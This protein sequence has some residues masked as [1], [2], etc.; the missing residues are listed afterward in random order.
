MET[1][2]VSSLQ[3]HFGFTEFRPGQVEALQS[4]MSGQHTLVVMPTGSGKSLIYQ[5]AALNF[6]GITLVL[7]PLVALMKDQ[8]DVLER[9]E[10]SA[11]FINSSLYST[12]QSRRLKNLAAGMYRLLYIAPE[13]LRSVPFLEALRHREVSLLAVDEAHCISEWGHDFRPDYLHIARFRASLGDPLTAALTA[14]ATPRVQEDITRLLNLSNIHRIVTGFN[15]PNL[16]LEV[17]Y[18]A[19]LYAKLKALKEFPIEGNG[20][21]TIIYTGTRRDSEEVADFVR[22]QVKL[23]A[24]YYHAGLGAEERDRIQDS[25]LSGKLP[26][27][28]ATKAF[29][30]GI[31]RQDVRQV[32]HYAIPGTLEAYYQEAGRAGRD[33]LPSHAVLL[34]S[35]EDRSL[36]EW[37]IE[38]S[39]VTISD[40]RMLFELIHKHPR[41]M[42][43]VTLNDLSLQLGI[44]ETK[45]KLG[46]A[47][48]E[49]AGIL[50]HSGDEGLRMQLKARDWETN[51]VQAIVEKLKQH[52]TYRQERLKDMIHYAESSHCRRIIILKYFGDPGKAEAEDCCDNCQASRPVSPSPARSTRQSEGGRVALLLLDT[53][54]WIKT[55]VGRDKVAKI[56]RGS[57]AKEIYSANLDKSPTFGC[58][59]SFSLDRIKELLDQLLEMGYLKVIGGRYPVLRLTPRGKASVQARD[60]IPLRL[61]HWVSSQGDLPDKA[62]TPQDAEGVKKSGTSPRNPRGSEISKEP[63]PVIRQIHALKHPNGNTRR[64]AASILGR[65]RDP[66]A[67][68]PLM[69]LLEREGKPQVRQY[70][71]IALG[72]IGDATA[73]ELLERIAGDDQEKIYTCQSA[74]EALNRLP[75]PTDEVAEFLAHS[76]LRPIKGPWEDGWALGFHSRFAGSDWQRSEVGE[77]AYRLKYMGDLSTLPAIIDHTLPLFEEHPELGKV[78]GVIPVPPS[79]PREQDPVS[80]YAQALSGRFGL[81]VY[82]VLIKSRHT[83]P[84]KEMRTMAQKRANVSGAFQLIKPVKGLR[85]LVVD[86]LF[87]SGATMD[88]ITRLLKR[89]G[90]LKVFVLT[91]TRTIHTSN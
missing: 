29:G 40:L 87:D 41:R 47:E 86:D 56:L 64:L 58:L 2:L 38:S 69:E 53:V 5:L 4:L 80:C 65:L 90:A 84:Q 72:K 83:Q 15:R 23:R 61:P 49:R 59:R 48:L 75:S 18:C 71:V 22:E 37:F 89:A 10:I 39:A 63:D 79:T 8:V 11:T 50:E 82:P 21:G 44:P 16:A 28:V 88:E 52:Q 9:R 1:D 60:P 67:V 24:E 6:P 3:N 45:V 26:I 77:L 55:P 46:L 78:D 76:H 27:V 30:M 33:G 66:R 36:Q 17:R 12:E 91:L 7:S 32:I 62:E 57:A 73:R 43:A 14:T 51:K 25:F 54:N 35:P 34:Y 13:R 70:A 19:D 20:G 68:R 31:D 81:A 42:E 74:R 85:L